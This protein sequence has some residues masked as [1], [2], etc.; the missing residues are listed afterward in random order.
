[1]DQCA[2]R[3]LRICAVHPGLRAAPG[4][5]GANAARRGA[6]IDR[7]LVVLLGAAVVLF[8]VGLRREVR[9]EFGSVRTDRL[10]LAAPGWVDPRWEELATVR[11]AALGPVDATV[12]AEVRA[13]VN[14]LSS[15]AFVEEV[16]A[17]TALWPDGLRVPLR[18][19]DVVACAR[20]GRHF[21]PISSTGAILPGR[22]PAP[23]PA[24]AGYLPVIGPVSADRRH[25][26]TGDQ[27]DDPAGLDGLDVA[28]SLWACL[29]DAAVER[30]GRIVID[31]THASR[32]APDE[33]GT[34]LL[35][36]RG[37]E[38]LFGRTPSTDRPGEL[39]V[40]TKWSSV[41]R[42]LELE[43]GVEPVDW[44]VVDV[45]WDRPELVLREPE[46]EPR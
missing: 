25:L 14:E 8:V 33:P 19:A 12:P 30:L 31:A 26:A 28:R 22:W 7:A 45:R 4:A 38:V 5:R 6:V 32:T 40:E 20:F 42:T 10:R 16:G 37:R 1:M 17:P 23:P 46:P 3:G 34:R 41:A 39:P 44:A 36:E 35:L 11:L 43:G 24:G 13:V 29:D 2:Q 18:T 27:L 15:L 21:Q 9:A